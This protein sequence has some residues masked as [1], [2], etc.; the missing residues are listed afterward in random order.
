MTAFAKGRVERSVPPVREDCFGGEQ[1]ADLDAARARGRIWALE[2][3]GTRRHSRTQQPPLVLFEGAERPALLPEPTTPYD[4]PIWASPKVARDQLAQVARALYS[5]PHR[6]VG[7]KLLARADAQLVRFYDRGALIKTHP[8]QPPG[9]R[10][11][12]PHDYPAE[13]SVYA[14]RNVEALRTQAAEHGPHIARYAAT[15]LDGPLP[16]TR[17]RRVYA[18]LGLVRRFGPSRVEEACG[19]ALTL[20]M[21]DV[22]RLQRMLELGHAMPPPAPPPRVLPRARYLRP[23]SQYALPLTGSAHPI[24]QGDAS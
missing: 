16:W 21:L 14:L 9:G 12:D 7:R 2:E 19:L 17:M 24:T 23:P 13:R 4:V 15:L 1:L 8:R 18:L 5:I 3:Y 20:D 11:I 10:A 22:R 6:H